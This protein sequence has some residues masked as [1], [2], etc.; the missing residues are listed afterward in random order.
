MADNFTEEISLL[1]QVHVA[2]GSASRLEDFYLIL[3]S[4]LVD[5]NTFGFSRAFV[6]RYDERTRCFLGKVALG[7]TSR[8]QYEQLREDLLAEARLLKDQEEAITRETGEPMALQHLYD[9]RFHSLWIQLLQGQ[10]E[11]TDLNTAFQE[12]S[13]RRDKLLPGHLLESA[14]SSAQ[15]RQFE[16]SEA[17]LEGLDKFVHLPA[18]AGR[19]V[20]KRGL[21]GV[22]I[23]DRIFEDRPLDGQDLYHF[24]WLINHASVSLENVLL[25]SELTETTNRMREVDR[26]K[27]NFLSIVSHELR[28]PL[29]SIVGFVHLLAEEKVGKI[30]PSQKDLLKRVSQHSTHLQNMVNDLLE[31]AEVESGGM[32]N[33]ELV[34]VDPLEALYAVMPKIEARRGAKNVAIEPSIMSTVPKILAD[35]SALERIYF[36]LLDNAVK[37]TNE[38][39]TVGIEFNRANG[40]LDISIVDQ[41]IGIPQENLQ[42]IF[43]NF[44]QVDYRL[45]R[46]YGGMG[47]GLTV[48]SL[49]LRALNGKINVE[50]TVGIGSR[51]TVTFPAISDG[52]ETNWH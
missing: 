30:T 21:H 46:A 23:A 9:L 51:F 18:L 15:A 32:V 13:L 36:H 2:L 24:Q 52:T 26:L 16:N 43:D 40:E 39:G 34:P 25:V 3:G 47:I 31:L 6:L 38:K 10:E 7:S 44:Y 35:Q 48:V 33:V 20:S 5:P 27:T 42:R 22:L 28:T 45:D 11:G 1:E 37:F 8:E 50:S 4:V 49:L 29:T 41:G 12:V 19:L 17:V 14:A